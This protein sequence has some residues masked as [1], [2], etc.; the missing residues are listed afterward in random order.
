MVLDADDP[1]NVAVAADAALA[2]PVMVLEKA[3]EAISA[4]DA[5]AAVPLDAK[6]D[7]QKVTSAAVYAMI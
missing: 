7:D 3:E 2:S 5:A 6:E 1:D 4:P